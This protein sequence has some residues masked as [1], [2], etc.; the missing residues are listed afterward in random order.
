MGP[1]RHETAYRQD[2]AGQ[3]LAFLVEGD[4][5]RIG[6]QEATESGEDRLQS[7]GR[8]GLGLE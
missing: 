5:G 7:D 4:D 6:A 2:G 8:C 3:P 1:W